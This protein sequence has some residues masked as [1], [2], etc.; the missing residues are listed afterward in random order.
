MD[1]LEFKSNVAHSNG[2]NGLKISGEMAPR[3]FPCRPTKNEKFKAPILDMFEENP[4][5][6]IT[7][8]NFTTFHNYRVSVI[9]DLL[10]Q[11]TFSEFR[12]AES[13]IAAF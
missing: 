4:A 3:T 10:G 5:I 11:V 8:Y 6:A 12:V 13:K 2:Y 1:L 9:A 7:F